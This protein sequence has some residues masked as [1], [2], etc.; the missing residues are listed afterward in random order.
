MIDVC[1]V[2]EGTYPFVS[3]GVSTWIHQLVTAMTDIRFSILYIS[4]YPNPRRELKYAVP[5]NVLDIQDLYLHEYRIDGR[6]TPRPRRRELFRRLA[7]L[8]E[9]LLGGRWAAFEDALPLIRDPERGVTMSDIFESQESW[10][11]LV[12]AY[13]KYGRAV[14]FVDFFWT[15]RSIYLPLMTTVTVPIPKARLYHT[16][17]TGYAGLVA[18]IA[19]ITQK[20][21]V[22]L[23]EHG[24][25]THERMLEI[26]QA[27]WIYSPHESRFRV[28]RE[29]PFF[30]RLWVG[31]F[32]TLGSI[33]Y[34]YSDRIVTLYE[35][36]RTKEILAGAD[37]ERISII[38]NG[39]DLDRYRDMKREEL[40]KDGPTIAFIGRVVAIKDVKTYLQAAKI[41]LA[42][43]PSARFLIMGPTD[44]EPEYMAECRQLVETLGLRDGVEF[45][46][47]VDVLEYLKRIDVVV[48][49]SLSEAQPYVILEANAAGVPVVA[50]DVG[51][52]R[53]MVEGRLR[54]DR[55]IGP[56]GIVTE[57][58]NAEQTAEAILR[59]TTETRLWKECSEAG[60]RRTFQF[61]D[62]N[63]LIS[64]YLNLYEQN[65]G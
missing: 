13:E 62:Q 33:S 14:S 41:V 48:L 45:T 10:E 43:R 28:R 35:G 60:R 12:A 6:R 25:Y 39:I 49:T 4:P 46:G 2:L 58:S 55:R 37:P 64:Q 23:T 53:E 57:V 8:H 16:V 38:P 47:K 27:S 40:S 18:A 56:S 29:L 51:A 54:E 5:P 63:D 31:L 11:V 1:L 50:T 32:N 20:K 9:G 17:S 3:G 30:K 34:H 65:M 26:S 21:G 36:N 7:E 19:R 22:L 15:W 59:L 52:C 24:V 42:Q 61:Y 44:E